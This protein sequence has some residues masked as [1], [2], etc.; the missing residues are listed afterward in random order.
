VSW[1]YLNLFS[2]FDPP[3]LRWSKGRLSFSPGVPVLLL[4]TTGAKSGHKR[5]TPLVYVADGERVVL[6]ASNGG[7]P[8]NPAWLYNLRAHPRVRATL[9]G[10]THDYAAREAEG[11]ERERLWQKALAVNPGYALYQEK[12]A[13]RRI[14]VVVLDPIDEPPAA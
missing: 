8:N 9:R 7:L 1:L 4:E 5:E 11:E 2:R 10:G 13:S 6:I 14:P 12:A 3:L